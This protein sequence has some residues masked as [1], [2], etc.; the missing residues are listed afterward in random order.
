[1][2]IS[3]ITFAV[4]LVVSHSIAIAQI[5]EADPAFLGDVL[6]RDLKLNDDQLKQLKKAEDLEKRTGHQI[7]ERLGQSYSGHYIDKN[8][9]LVALS[10]APDAAKRL[11]GLEIDTVRTVSHSW[12]DLERFKNQLVAA[13]Q[14]G[15]AREIQFIE[16]D[17]ERNRARIAPLVGF[18]SEASSIQRITGLSDEHVFVE[19]VAN[20]NVPAFTIHGGER[21]GYGQS[22][23]TYQWSWCS[24]GFPAYTEWGGGAWGFVSAG[25]CPALG[26]SV[27]SYVTTPNLTFGPQIGIV[28]LANYNIDGDYAWAHITDPNFPIEPWVNVGSGHIPV[29]GRWPAPVGASVCRS[30]VTTGWRCGVIQS[31]S[32]TMLQAPSGQPQLWVGNMRRSSACAEPGDSGGSQ[33]TPSGEAQGIVSAHSGL[34]GPS[35][36][37]SFYQDLDHA[38]K[39]TGELMGGVYYEP[40]VRNHNPCGRVNPGQYIPHSSI[41]A[42]PTLTACGSSLYAV[43]WSPSGV[44]G[45]KGG[46]TIVDFN[47]GPGG[48]LRVLGDGSMVALNSANVLLWQTPSAGRGAELRL[49]PNGD[50]TLVSPAGVVAWSACLN[51]GAPWDFT[52]RCYNDG[53]GS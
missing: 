21:W 12:D 7:R 18:E 34:C 46:A 14:A 44:V 28:H 40:I 49:A 51:P 25:H 48:R 30:G 11:S 45:T 36:S 41:S 13:A 31:T 32:A 52:S 35:T 19:S 17:T 24:M 9:N 5:R 47:T 39:R 26:S 27:T 6:R 15:Q 20:R 8:Q 10:T 33:I 2:T 3:R 37:H 29:W 22:H 1:V 4:L 23:Y 16:V 42:V 38:L 53:G 43:Q 50:L